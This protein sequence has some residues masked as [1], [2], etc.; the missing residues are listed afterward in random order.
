[1]ADFL[2]S[3]GRSRTLTEKFVRVNWTLLLA[4][5]TLVAIGTMSLYSTADGSLHPWAEA[6]ALRFVVCVALAITIAMV[7]P[8]VWM[9][10]AVPVYFIALV[11]LALVPVFGS[12]ALGAKRWIGVA[13][14]KFQPS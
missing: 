10:L 6:H 1:M 13:G 8:R 9:S 3:D 14:L 5:A 12:E 7:P 4:I 2:F 11:V